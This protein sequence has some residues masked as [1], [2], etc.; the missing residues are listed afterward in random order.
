MYSE[1]DMKLVKHAI[2]TIDEIDFTDLVTEND[3]PYYVEHILR[4]SSK[5]GYNLN[6]DAVNDW[7]TSYY[8]HRQEAE[9]FWSNMSE[10]DINDYYSANKTS[11]EDPDEARQIAATIWSQLNYKPVIPMSWGVSKR[12]F[13]REN[14]SKK[15]LGGLGFHVN[16]RKFKGY[17]NVWLT[18]MDEYLVELIN[19]RGRVLKSFDG[20]YADDLADIIDKEIET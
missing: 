4:V 2:D 15:A 7:V 8:T 17:V 3:I 6:R 1:K 16:G 18:Y 13:M 10:A 9:A 19:N 12:V 14:E 11:S 5:L 20:V